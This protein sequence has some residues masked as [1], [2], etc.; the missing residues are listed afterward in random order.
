MCP[1]RLFEDCG[2]DVSIIPDHAGIGRGTGTRSSIVQAIVHK[3]VITA[4]HDHAMLA[5]SDRVVWIAEGKI[6][7]I[8]K[9]SELRIKTGTVA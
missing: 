7:R 4:T 2:R 9:S 3:H 8:A 1:I 5:V 6:E